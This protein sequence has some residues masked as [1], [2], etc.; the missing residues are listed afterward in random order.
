MQ[1]EHVSSNTDNARKMEQCLTQEGI[2]HFGIQGIHLDTAG[3]ENE[4][5]SMY[6]NS[7]SRIH[8]SVA[9]VLHS[10]RR[11]RWLLPRATADSIDLLSPIS[12][13][14]LP[15]RPKLETRIYVCVPPFP[16]SAG[17]AFTDCGNLVLKSMYE[18]AGGNAP[19]P[20]WYPFI[21]RTEVLYT[22]G[23]KQ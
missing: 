20:V 3:S 21:Y 7:R 18:R 13:H 12:K 2:V 10:L 16:V 5:R 23:A 14:F 17:F 9:D 1:R 6:A 19:F 15:P 22:T 8:S 11:L 4:R